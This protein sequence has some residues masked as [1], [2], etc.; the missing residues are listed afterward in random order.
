MKTKKLFSKPSREICFSEEF[1]ERIDKAYKRYKRGNLRK[2]QKQLAKM[3]IKKDIKGFIFSVDKVDKSIFRVE[4]NYVEKLIKMLKFNYENAGPQYL[5]DDVYDTMLT[6]FKIFR[7]EPISSELVIGDSDR[8]EATTVHEYPHLKGTLDK[9]K[10]IISDDNVPDSYHSSVEKFIDRCLTA[11]KEL[12]MKSL[13]FRISFKYDGTSVVLAFNKYGELKSAITRGKGGKGVDIS[14]LFPY[15]SVDRLSDGSYPVAVQCEIMMSDNNIKRY[16]SEVDY[17]YKNSRGSVTSVLTSLDGYKYSKFLDL[18]PLTILHDNDGDIERT[19]EVIEIDGY[20]GIPYNHINLS[21]EVKEINEELASGILSS[22]AAYAVKISTEIRDNLGY[23]IDGL[24]VET[25]DEELVEYLGRKGEI[26]QYQTAYKFTSSEKETILRDVTYS[27]GRTGLIIP[28]AIYD[29]VIFN[30]TR[31]TKATLASR[32][33]MN[34]FNMAI[35][36]TVIIEYAN[37]VIPYF[38]GISHHSGNKYIKFPTVCPICK[39]ELVEVGAHSYC[40]NEDCE[41]K[42]VLEYTNFMKVLGYRNFS[43]KF[44]EKLFEFN[45]IHSYKDLLTLDDK[46]HTI[47]EEVDGIGYK[48]LDAYSDHTKSIIGKVT[49]D[50]ILHAFGITGERISKRIMLA[51]DLHKLLD[52]PYYLEYVAVD[53]LADSK[54]DIINK[55]K[56]NREMMIEVCNILEP[57]PVPK[58]E[59]EYEYKVCFTGFRDKELIEKLKEKKVEVVSGFKNL[60]Y[61]VVPDLTYRNAKTSK[62][63]KQDIDVIDIQTLKEIFKI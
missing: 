9:C 12:R 17:E 54:K 37:D 2:M 52:D 62:A 38:K 25:T 21:Y 11:A 60:N 5:V 14:K 40:M 19:Y 30:G 3:N 8:A 29:E 42:K 59:A 7:E 56:K 43:N 39:H 33:N 57:I 46:F 27:V 34:S 48:M 50:K 49:E 1:I 32:E 63:E 61:L 41:A 53:G 58:E 55:I 31:Q 15:L 20:N 24:V 28:K 35:G 18:V 23:Q 44:I 4:L 36:D 45:L 22:I 51:T 26:N 6:R 16:S 47:I 13:N 10:F